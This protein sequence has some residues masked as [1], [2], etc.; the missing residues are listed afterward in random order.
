[1][2]GHQFTDA[3]MSNL[4]CEIIKQT[5]SN[6]E[7]IRKSETTTYGRHSAKSKIRKL[8]DILTFIND[9]NNYWWDCLSE[10]TD[11]NTNKIQKRLKEKIM[12]TYHKIEEE[13][14]SLEY[15]L[16]GMVEPYDIEKEKK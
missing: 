11:L 3:G 8:Q 9:K 15:P 2:N 12:Q 6:I 5:N 14:G 1:M 13:R 10:F 16:G 7:T 4:I